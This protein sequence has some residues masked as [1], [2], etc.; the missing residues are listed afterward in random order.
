[1]AGHNSTK[2]SMSVCPDKPDFRHK[3]HSCHLYV[4]EKYRC[5][6]QIL[7]PWVMAAPP[8][9]RQWG[10]ERVGCRFPAEL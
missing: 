7:G 3:G 5:L 10:L 8:M 1:M 9:L 4:W 6:H 2:Y